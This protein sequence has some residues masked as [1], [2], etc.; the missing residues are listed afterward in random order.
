[1]KRRLDTR[2][3]GLDIG[4]R[5]ARWLTGAENLHYG[6]WT[7]LDVNAGNLGA[8]QTA[9]T[10][11]LL[12][13]LPD[14]PLS[15][16]DIGGGA[17]E[18]AKRLVAL[19][20]RVEIVVPSAYLA[21][22]CRANAPDAQVHC[23]TLQ[24][25]ETD[26]RFDLC[27]FS[28]SLQYIPLETALGKAVALTGAGGRI[29]IADCFRSEAFRRGGPIRSP[30]GGHPVEDVR[31]MLDTLPV[32]I[33]A[34][35][36]ITDGVAPSIDLEQGFYATIGAALERVDAELAQKRPAARWMIRRALSL[37][38]RR[39]SRLRIAARLR[40]DIRNSEIFRRDNRYLIV[41]LRLSDKRAPAR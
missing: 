25:F 33:L 27:L 14:G 17:G 4:V 15:I 28:E 29:L 11:R 40:G 37:V 31:R 39:K 9:F 16:L 10:D 36:D 2:S 12:S 18:T 19:G 30:G 21:D 41:S 3:I 22:R 24:E 1:M 34:Q 5:F 6:L 23:T 13:H 7:G 32:E 26:A 35:E 8:A 38:L 20:H